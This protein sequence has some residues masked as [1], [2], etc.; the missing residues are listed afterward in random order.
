M[1]RPLAV[2]WDDGGRAAAGF[3]GIARDC[4][5]RSIAIATERPYREIYCL[6]N[7]M[8]TAER[9]SRR[10]AKSGRS[11]A[12][13]GVYHPT[14]RRIMAALG[15]TW[16]PTMKVGSPGRVHLAEGELP[17]EGRLVVQVS[18]HVTA[19]VDGV[20]RDNHNP[21]RGGTRLVYGYFV[22]GD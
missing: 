22:K 11:S 9:M 17:A 15:W 20:I 3:K 12:R 18:R 21:T 14:T 8:A 7:T 4:V 19:V 6:I 5:C 13:K 1:V 10:R 2:I 16:V